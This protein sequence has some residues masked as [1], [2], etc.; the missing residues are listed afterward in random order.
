MLD[1][2]VGWHS[3]ASLLAVTQISL[4]CS[5]SKLV[6][7]SDQSPAF[8]ANSN[9]DRS[10]LSQHSLGGFDSR[11]MTRAQSHTLSLVRPTAWAKSFAYLAR[12]AQ[13]VRVI[14]QGAAESL[15]LHDAGR[16]CTTDQRQERRG[17]EDV[18]EQVASVHRAASE[19][20]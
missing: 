12:E 8:G 19:G 14:R 5:R 9:M 2:L 4:V 10:R 20:M 3:G 16:S 17:G 7:D 6:R 1:L 13:P 15:P 11:P 18:I